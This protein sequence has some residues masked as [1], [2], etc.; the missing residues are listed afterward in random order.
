MTVRQAAAKLEV[1]QATIYNLIAAGK[2]RCERHG[3]GR[4]CI[5]ISEDQLAA[6][7]VVA[8]GVPSPP[9][10]PVSHPRLKHINL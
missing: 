5:R 8:A 3:L 7:R 4:G 6:Y 9:P 2:L 1:S 10:A